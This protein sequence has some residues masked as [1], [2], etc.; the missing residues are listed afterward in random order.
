M[1]H[2]LA[3][4]TVMVTS[5]ARQ[6][7]RVSCRWCSAGAHL[8]IARGSRRALWQ[9]AV[10]ARPRVEWRLQPA[11]PQAHAAQA[12]GKSLTTSCSKL[13]AMFCCPQVAIFG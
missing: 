12:A 6:L 4:G 7:A 10:A 3:Q 2:S 9:G 5:K 8:A 11:R 1:P 13:A